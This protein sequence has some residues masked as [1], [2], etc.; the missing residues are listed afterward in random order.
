MKIEHLQECI[1]L[2]KT[3]NFTQTSR[4]FYITQPVLSKHISGIEHELGIRVFT[5]SPH[6]VRLTE[7]GRV[8]I[9]DAVEV[10]KRYDSALDNVSRLKRGAREQLNVGYLL[11][12]G[13]KILPPVIRRFSYRVPQTALRFFSLEIT[14]IPELLRK[15]V[16]DI[17][18]TTD[19]S[20]ASFSPDLYGKIELFP[21]RYCAVVPKDHPLASREIVSLDELKD[22]ELLTAMPSFMKDEYEGKNL[23]GTVFHDIS[24]S[25]NEVMSFF[26]LMMTGTYVSIAY[27]HLE[28]VFGDEFAYLPVRELDKPF[29][30]FA[31]WEKSREQDALLSFADE[32]VQECRNQ[33][34]RVE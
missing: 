22:E 16:I 28:N 26:L 10:V 14:E 34:L 6:G 1:H 4:A 29:S 24:Y 21:D 33:G 15:N 8:F 11:G 13:Y 2:A 7:E 17:G 12:V 27:K 32:L 25:I 20:L 23:G 18:I 31:V 5:R 30:T 9:Q 19:E 3:L